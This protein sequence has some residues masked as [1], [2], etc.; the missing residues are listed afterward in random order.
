MTRI[1]IFTKLRF[2]AALAPLLW[3]VAAPIL[4]LQLYVLGAMPEILNQDQLQAMRAAHGMELALYKMDWG[5]TQPDGMQIVKDQQR[6]FVNWVSLAHDHLASRAQY[7]A[8]NRI[9]AAAN[10]IFDAMRKAEPGDQ[11]FEPDLIKLQGMIAALASADDAV[12]GDIASRTHARANLMIAIVVVAGLLVPWGCLA[13]LARVSSGAHR[14]LRELR[15]YLDDLLDRTGEPNP[16]LRAIDDRM[17]ELGYPKHNPM[18]A[19]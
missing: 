5:R 3:L 7:D 6:Q 16:D 18:L 12:L 1:T 9:T 2:M 19:E 15:R 17:A 4:A 14:S 10:P 8:L 11:S 13:I